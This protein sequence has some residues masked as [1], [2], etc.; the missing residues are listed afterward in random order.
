[1][2]V[3]L[4]GGGKLMRTVSRKITAA[5]LLSWIATVASPGES[6]TDEELISEATGAA[7]PEVAA[8]ATVMAPTKVGGLRMLRV[9]SNAFTCLPATPELGFPAMCLD[10]NGLAWFRAHRARVRPLPGMVGFGYA[11]SGCASGCAHD[12]AAGGVPKTVG[13]RSFVMIMN[14][15]R[16][17]V[18]HWWSYGEEGLTQPS[19]VLQDT[20]YEYLMIPVQ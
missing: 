16:P 1:M 8:E 4:V 11:L 18:D 17:A 5:I 6:M 14:L 19:V 10:H 9:G 7:P 15:P 2:N 20:Q 13:S 12:V 3:C